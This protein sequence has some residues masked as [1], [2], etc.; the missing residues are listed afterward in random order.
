MREKALDEKK[1][2]LIDSLKNKEFTVVSVLSTLMNSSKCLIDGSK[3]SEFQY[4]ST[5]KLD[6]NNLLKNENFSVD[7]SELFYIVLALESKAEIMMDDI[8]KVP[9]VDA[10]QCVE[11]EN[12]VRQQNM[13]LETVD[14]HNDSREIGDVTV[15]ALEREEKIKAATIGGIIDIKV[16]G[17]VR[18]FYSEATL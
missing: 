6:R 14:N 2:I 16:S 9:I 11:K 3:Y 18:K 8:I 12:V 15:Q 7:Y 10:W 4:A 5:L 17:S 1:L 13:I